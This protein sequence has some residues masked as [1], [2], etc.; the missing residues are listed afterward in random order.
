MKL[1]TLVMYHV[2]K[3]MALN[4]YRKAYDYLT[5]AGFDEIGSGC[6]SKVYSRKG[7]EYVIKI[8]IQFNP[9][10]CSAIHDEDVPNEKHFASMA[11]FKSQAFNVIVQQKCETTVDKMWRKFDIRK[12]NKYSEKMEQKY[13]VQDVHAGNV[14]I[15]KG[16]FIII[17]WCKQEESYYSESF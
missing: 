14:G 16:R 17:D 3:L 8:K 4:S 12:F 13:K 1:N 15:I 5:N 2:R 10:E 9:F 7:F 11:I 6:E